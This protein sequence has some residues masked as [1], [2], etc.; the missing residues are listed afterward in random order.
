M[1]LSPRLDSAL[2]LASHIH[3]DQTR[4]DAERTPYISHLVAVMLLVSDVTKDEDI[5]IAA[6]LHDAIEDVA[7]FTEQDLKEAFGDRVAKLVYHVTE[8]QAKEDPFFASIPWLTRKEL[9][10]ARLEEGEEGSLLISTAD[11]LHNLTSFLT[12][13]EREGETFLSNFHGSIKNQLWFYEEVLSRVSQRLGTTHPLVEALNH[14]VAEAR[15]Y[16]KD[17]I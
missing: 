4:R 14:K 8:P 7:N 10:L 15:I 11:K 9:Y 12:D 5:L 13:A 16:F 17:H 6:L 1:I 3:R 2:K